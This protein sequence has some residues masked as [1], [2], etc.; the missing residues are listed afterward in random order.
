MHKP[1][2]LPFSELK[3]LKENTYKRVSLSKDANNRL[4]VAKQYRGHKVEHSIA[5]CQY[6]Y[7]VLRYFHQNFRDVAFIPAP[8]GIDRDSQT[9]YLEYFAQLLKARLLTRATLALANPFFE[10]C[11]ELTKLASFRSIADSIAYDA[12][13]DNWITGGKRISL[14]LKGDLWQNLC[15]TESGLMFADIDSAATEPLGF[16]E[17]VMRCEIVAGFRFSNFAGQRTAGSQ[18][19]C[20]RYLDSGDAKEVA[21]QALSLVNRRMSHLPG[22]IAS[23]KLRIARRALDADIERYYR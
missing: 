10:R 18:P 13:I 23:M 19:V 8:L 17:L 22:P 16:S 12:S 15:A 1:L 3:I 21:I 4:F 9:I 6:A 11:Y 20:F 14:G 5:N 7:D 2:R